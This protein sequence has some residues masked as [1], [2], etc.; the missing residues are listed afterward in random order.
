MLP[1]SETSLDGKS[2]DPGLGT[3]VILLEL[4]NGLSGA[5]TRRLVPAIEHSDGVS[6]KLL[7]VAHDHALS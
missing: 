7:L 2:P 5:W 4:V 3:E 6:G 1:D